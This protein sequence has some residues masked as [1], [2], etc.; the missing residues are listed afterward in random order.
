MGTPMVGPNCEEC[1]HYD[2]GGCDWNEMVYVM[3]IIFI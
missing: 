2:N 3:T 1:I